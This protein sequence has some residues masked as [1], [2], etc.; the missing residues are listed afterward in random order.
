VVLI[1]QPDGTYVPLTGKTE[2]PYGSVIDAEEGSVEIATEGRKGRTRSATF[3]GAKFEVEDAER[4]RLTDIILRGGG[5]NSCPVKPIGGRKSKKK[6]PKRS[7]FASGGSGHRTTGAYGSATVRG[8]EWRTIDTC[9]G[10]RLLA[11]EHS[12]EVEDFVTGETETVR[13]GESYFAKAR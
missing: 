13:E 11:I 3:S 6:K 7:L 1:R 10:T 9:K 5:I 4:G 2:I 8:T 12:I